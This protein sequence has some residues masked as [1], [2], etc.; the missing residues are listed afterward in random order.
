MSTLGELETELRAKAEA[1]ERI[2]VKLGAAEDWDG[3]GDWLDAIAEEVDRGLGKAGE[4]IRV[5]SPTDIP[6]WRA[7]ANLMGIEYD[8][9]DPEPLA[10]ED[11][12]YERDEAER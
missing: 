6:A 11:V 4:L 1:F 12:V 9:P 2:A 5:G 10:A 3:A 8:D 7:R